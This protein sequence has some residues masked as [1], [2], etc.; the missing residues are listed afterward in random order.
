MIIPIRTEMVARRTPIA[1]VALITL[2]CA[3]FVL[4][5]LST[6]NQAS[7]FREQYLIL[8]AEWPRLFQFLTY[9]FS[10][11]DLWHLLGNMLF[12]WVFGNSVN[13]KMGDIA[14]VL[15]YL[16]GGVF[17]A[18]V[19]TMNDTSRMLGASGAIAAVTTAYLALF[20]RSRVTVMYIFFFIGFFELPATILIL[21]KIILWDNVIAPSITPGA[22]TGVAFSA[23][24]GGYIFGFLTAALL[25][26]TRAVARDHFDMLALI[27]RWHRRR[28]F[29]AVMSDPVAQRRAQFGTVARSPGV[30]SAERAADEA[31]LDA[32]TNLRAQIVALLAK[33]DAAAAARTYEQL[34]AIDP[35]QCLSARN[36]LQVAREFYGAGRTPQAANA[37]ERYLNSYSGGVEADEISLLLG[38]IYARDLQRYEEAEKRLAATLNHLSG[39]RQSQCREWLDTVRRALGK[40]NPDA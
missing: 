5:N 20:P 6:S 23:H 2:N 9:Q 26:A 22:M 32:V 4:F 19:F 1:N 40:E 15:F 10:H 11:G 28:A 31:R 38:I 18:I 16:T 30:S 34:T 7:H 27:D 36:Q 12:L 13:A 17:A 37:F 25:L 39:E 21:F 24:L 14:Y 8:D 3:V 35:A 33:G 29:Q